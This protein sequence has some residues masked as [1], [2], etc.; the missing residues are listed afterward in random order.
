MK[1]LVSCLIMTMLIFC[2]N[3]SLVNASAI[4]KGNPVASYSHDGIISSGRMPTVTGNLS[5]SSRS[6]RDYQTCRPNG[7]S[8]LNS[9]NFIFSKSNLHKD[10]T[11]PLTVGTGLYFLGGLRH[12]CPKPIIAINPD[13]PLLSPRSIFVI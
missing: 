1:K 8:L 12:T 7:K 5:A 10:T 9:L 3:I 2:T 11:R 4:E 6:L 13:D